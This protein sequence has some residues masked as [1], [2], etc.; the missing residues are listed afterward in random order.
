MAFA[1]QRHFAG[2]SCAL[3]DFTLLSSHF[4][5]FSFRLRPFLYG[6]LF[7]RRVAIEMPIHD[8]MRAAEAGRARA[9]PRHVELD[10]QIPATYF[11]I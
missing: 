8:A 6:R 10:R 5:P 9:S 7:L 3:I 11:S 1:A 2:L 4:S